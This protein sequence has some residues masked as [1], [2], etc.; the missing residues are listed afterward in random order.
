M[1]TRANHFLVGCFVLALLAGVFAAGTWFARANLGD[2]STYY[3]TYFRGA[4]TGLS[5]GST[6]RYRGVPVGTVSDIAIDDQNLELIQVT[7]ALRPDTPVRTDT[8]AGLQP[9]GITGLSFIQLTGGTQGAEPLRPRPGR[10]RAVI[11]SVPSPL[12]KIMSDAPL[13]VAR[14]AELAERITA[15]LN[16][17]NIQNLDR[18]IDNSADAAASLARAMLSIEGVVRNIDGTLRNVDSTLAGYDGVAADARALVAELNRLAATAGTLTPQA[19]AMIDEVRR[20]AGGFGRVA[21]ELEKLASAT[22]PGMQDFGQSGLY[23]LQQFML[24]GRT[25]MTTLNRV[26]TNFE[27]DPARFLF[28][29]QQKGL[30]AK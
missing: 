5:T 27:R 15:L 28:G 26:V 25:L 30:E 4:V 24:E 21:D 19:N 3:Y 22:R 9:Q 11:P 10:R 12:D 17:E 16:E 13:V 2:E 6:V 14:V 1:E 18:L 7:L 29:D 23:E 20:T 8:V